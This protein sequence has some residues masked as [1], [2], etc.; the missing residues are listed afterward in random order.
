MAKKNYKR[1][2]NQQ[3][4]IGTTISSIASNSD[5][6]NDNEKKSNNGK[7]NRRTNPRKRT[8]K[9][10]A[11]AAGFQLNPPN[12]SD[13]VKKLLEGHMA[14]FNKFLA[15]TV[16]ECSTKKYEKECAESLK[17]VTNPDTHPTAPNKQAFQ[18]VVRTRPVSDHNKTFTTLVK[19]TVPTAEQ[20]QAFI[21]AGRNVP[22]N[23]PTT[24]AGGGPV[25]T[26]GKSSTASASSSSSA[27]AFDPDL[28]DV[29][30]DVNTGNLIMIPKEFYAEVKL[31]ENQISARQLK[32]AELDEYKRA[33]HA[34]QEEFDDKESKIIK[35]KKAI[36]TFMWDLLSQPSQRLVADKMNMTSTD[37]AKAAVEFD[38]LSQHILE[39][40]HPEYHGLSG[41]SNSFFDDVYSYMQGVTSQGAMSQKDAETTT[42]YK[43]RLMELWRTTELAHN[44]SVSAPATASKYVKPTLATFISDCIKGASPRNA[45]VYRLCQA[46]LGRDAVTTLQRPATLEDLFVELEKAEALTA[47]KSSKKVKKVARDQ[48]TSEVTSV[49]SQL[50]TA[51]G[52]DITSMF[53]QSRNKNSRSKQNRESESVSKSKQNHESENARKSKPK[54]YDKDKPRSDPPDNKDA[55]RMLVN[56]TKLKEDERKF[57]LKELMKIDPDMVRSIAAGSEPQNLSKRKRDD[58]GRHRQKAKNIKSMYAQA[59][60]GEHDEEDSY[61]LEYDSSADEE[62]DDDE[63]S[64]STILSNFLLSYANSQVYQ[65]L[66]SLELEPVSD[67]Y[68][69]LLGLT[70]ESMPSTKS[71]LQYN[72]QRF[73]AVSKHRNM[74]LSVSVKGVTCRDSGTSLHI[75]RDP[76]LLV[77]GSVRRTKKSSRTK[78]QGALPGAHVPKFLAQHKLLGLCIFDPQARA[79]LVSEVQAWASG[80][81]FQLDNEKFITTMSHPHLDDKY[82][83]EIGRENVPLAVD[84]VAFRGWNPTFSK[85]PV[86]LLSNFIS[87]RL[88]SQALPGNLSQDELD[89]DQDEVES[90]AM[91]AVTDHHG[92]QRK[93]VKFHTTVA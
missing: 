14:S 3:N 5:A 71:A 81:Q 64:D 24:V 29:V 4:I 39:V 37:L 40:H 74:K 8:G 83:F 7:N 27:S 80:W 9:H 23:A 84:C 73:D 92:R 61:D 66:L 2:V 53:V 63:E 65:S 45:Q 28:Y 51:S 54:P 88:I 41:G 26:R 31:T 34:G 21:D 58:E 18:H 68:L 15:L 62:E 47:S 30:T 70:D 1:Q 69:A 10:K 91:A 93:R 57:M 90:I 76:E 82:V 60:G 44:I 22:T 49:I 36:A 33:L 35:E 85:R 19:G 12:A 32:S 17:L 11:K 79:N 75:V 43:N 48:L 59:Q 87:E 13:S 89:I 20:R 67:T 42:E 77:K 16:A 6:A 25:S 56:P 78:V 52:G 86:S 38:T 50:A 55:V 72:K 46:Y